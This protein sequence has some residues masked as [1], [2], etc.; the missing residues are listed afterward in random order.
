[1]DREK[2]PLLML[3]I[4]MSI[5]LVLVVAAYAASP[6]VTTDKDTYYLTENIT[7]SVQANPLSPYK[8]VIIKCTNTTV[9]S[10][11]IAEDTIETLLK[12][13]DV[14]TG[15]IIDSCSFYPDKLE[16]LIKTDSSGQFE[17]VV[18]TRDTVKAAGM[19]I[20]ELLDCNTNTKYS[21]KS[22]IVKSEKQTI[23]ITKTTTTTTETTTTE[24]TTETT[25]TTTTPTET[26]T[27]ITETK[28]TE[29]TITTE[30]PLVSPAELD[31]RV[32]LIM[33]IISILLLVIL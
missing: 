21:L 8:L 20:V 24:T 11:I 18:R 12:I 33:L 23:T 22:F 32:S 15:T 10:D 7:I 2:K 3:S 17:M 9:D 13:I 14:K 31:S 28:P 5:S 30:T 4:A 25:T 27:E 16:M 6:T 19:Y 29:T 26:E 1:M